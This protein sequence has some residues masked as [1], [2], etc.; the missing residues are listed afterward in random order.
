MLLIVLA[1]SALFP[2]PEPLPRDDPMA[3]ILSPGHLVAYAIQLPVMMLF[4]YAAALSHW[5]GVTAGKALF[6]SVVALWKNMGAFTVFSLAWAAV[7]LVVSLVLTLG[8][9]VG[10]VGLLL[11]LAIP[12]TLVLSAM[13]LASVYFTFR[14]SFSEDATRRAR[15][16]AATRRRCMS[17]DTPPAAIVI[18]GRGVR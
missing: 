18:A 8:F 15:V 5:H 6:F 12:V 9:A 3:V 11:L 1:T 14:D 7:T 10:G 17:L 4:C 13:T 2:L 16:A